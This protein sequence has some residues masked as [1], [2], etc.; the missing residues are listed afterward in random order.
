MRKMGKWMFIVMLTICMLLPSMV[1]NSKATA[2]SDRN[3]SDLI[4]L[5]NVP[6]SDAAIKGNNMDL[7]ALN[8]YEDGYFKKVNE[9]LKWSSKNRKVATVD[10]EGTV[11]FSGK[12]GRAWI[13]VTNGDYKDRIAVHVKPDHPKKEDAVNKKVIKEKGDRY[14][15]VAHALENMTIEEKVGQMLMPDYRNWDGENV[16]EMLPEI[17]AQIQEYHLGGV[18]LFRENVVTTEQTTKL[19]ADYQKASEKYGMLMTIDQEG[20]IVTRLQSGTDMPGNMALRGNTFTELAQNV[21][22]AMEKS[23]HPLVLT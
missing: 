15:L 17:E 5:Q 16:T 9:G 10:K 8:V 1:T 6:Q 21:G 12:P 18:I 7:S 11:T 2:S 4:I 23:L 19:V 14:D 22:H 20:G 3:T 13:T